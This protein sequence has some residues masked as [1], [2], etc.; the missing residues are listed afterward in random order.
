[1]STIPNQGLGVLCAALGGSIGSAIRV[2]LG[3]NL[4]PQDC[5]ITNSCNN[6]V[7]NSTSS[8]STNTTL[9]LPNESIDSTLPSSLLLFKAFPV[10]TFLANIIGTF[11]VCFLT[12]IMDTFQ[13]NTYLRIFIIGGFCGGLTTMSG[14]M[15]EIMRLYRNAYIGTSIAYACITFFTCLIVGIISFLCGTLVQPSIK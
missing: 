14:F 10:A 6:L 11:I 12:P 13:W 15:L 2:F 5:I 7:S 4:P 1:M 3:F 8:N 9:P